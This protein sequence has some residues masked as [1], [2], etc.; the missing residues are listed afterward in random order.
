[1]NKKEFLTTLEKG[2][3]TLPKD[4]KER[5]Y[6]YYHETIEDR[7]E[8]GL[9]EEEALNGMEDVKSI[10]AEALCEYQIQEDE[11]AV[12]KKKNHAVYYA[13]FVCASPFILTFLI[14]LL[15]I[16][17]FLWSLFFSLLCI[18]A[19]LIIFV[20][21][22]VI[23]TIRILRLNFVSGVVLVGCILLSAGACPWVYKIIKM[24]YKSLIQLWRYGIDKL[25]GMWKKAVN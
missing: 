24:T 3:K 7:I 4:E 23:Y 17:V 25:L 20:I 21:I 19:S 22:G 5:I 9:S 1:M 2:I 6:N 10:I 12:V 16:Y 14:M 15:S 13:L 11:H 8:E 18:F